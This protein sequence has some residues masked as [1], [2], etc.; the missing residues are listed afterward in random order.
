MCFR[1]WGGGIPNKVYLGGIDD[2]VP[3]F[4][5]IG[6]KSTFLF[7]HNSPSIGRGSGSTAT[8]SN[9]NSSCTSPQPQMTSS[10]ELNDSCSSLA[11]NSSNQKTPIL[12][13]EFLTSEEY[14][15][16]S[17]GESTNRLHRELYFGK[18]ND[19][20]RRKL[21]EKWI[22]RD[23]IMYADWGFTRDPTRNPHRQPMTRIFDPLARHFNSYRLNPSV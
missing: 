23:F 4:L 1:V 13:S 11:G 21:L 22:P 20:V 19:W 16:P 3:I 9:D 10:N 14:D 12:N 15:K 2:M 18:N 17:G 5:S 6:K 8:G 7:I